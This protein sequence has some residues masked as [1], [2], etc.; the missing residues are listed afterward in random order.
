M[1]LV[2]VV[3]DVQDGRELLARVLRQLGGHETITADGGQRALELIDQQHPALVV[4]DIA[5]PGMDGFEV[6]ETLQSRE[7][8][9]SPPVVMLTAFHDQ[10]N[11]DRA[12]DLGAAD[13]FV[14]G[15]LDL[16]Q[17]LAKVAALV[18]G[19]QPAAG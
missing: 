2:L 14:K 9:A 4:L 17:L 8:Q 16:S 7:D 18:D 1:A 13:Y 6:L 11:R 3:D 15:S 5:M 19:D 10:A 12:A